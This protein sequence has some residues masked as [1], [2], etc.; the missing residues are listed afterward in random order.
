MT[1]YDKIK[2]MIFT[3]KNLSYFGI[4][5]I[6]SSIILALFWF[7]IASIVNTDDYGKIS[8]FIA[9]A[10]IVTVLA[11]PG[12]A[13][14]LM[15]HSS[16]NQKIKSPLFLI[17]IVLILLSSMILFF[18]LNNFA[19]SL[20]LLGYAT[21][22]VIT[23]ELLSRQLFGKLFKIIIIQR[24]LSIVI[25][26]SL[27]YIIGLDGIIFGLAISYLI[28][29]PKFITILKNEPFNISSLKD[30]RGFIFTNYG[31][32]LSRILATQLD[33]LV[34]FPLFGFITLGNYYLA[35][36]F[37]AIGIIIPGT[38]YQYI[39]PQESKEKPF[40][41]L[42]IATIATSILIS[43]LI[44]VLVPLLFTVMFS[45]FIDAITMI[46]IMIISLIPQTINLMYITK[47]LTKGNSKIV[48]LGSIIF[49]T[50]QI[51]SIIILGKIMGIYGIAL[52]LLLG[53]STESIY[54]I[55]CN[56]YF[57]DKK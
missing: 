20:Y 42:K 37:L 55:I 33:K 53:H 2:S 16:K 40:K 14:T 51:T 24:I 44:I 31:Y 50:V 43:V 32:D 46:Q 56:R 27:Y 8:Y 23:S 22:T 10:S 11:T 17:S 52:A 54:L 9:I 28:Y 47:F 36:Q 57:D 34:I 12:V 26:L 18:I 3:N 19:T 6:I 1:F 25:S 35:T 30:Y 45:N 41:N 21:F 49:I 7:L 4:A 29:L 13:N 15:V 38:V 39:L 5:N 48:L